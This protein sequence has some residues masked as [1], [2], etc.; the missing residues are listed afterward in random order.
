M[1][2]SCL[3]ESDGTWKLAWKLPWSFACVRHRCLLVDTCPSCKRRTG[4]GHLNARSAPPFT[5]HI[6]IPSTCRN[7]LLPLRGSPRRAPGICGHQLDAVP[8]PPL[9]DT[10]LSSILEAQRRIDEALEGKEQTIAGE[11]V[12]SLEYFRDLRSACAMILSFGTPEDIEGVTPQAREAFALYA[13]EREALREE[14]RALVAAGGHWR[15]GPYRQPYTA[16]QHSAALMAAIVPRA[17]TVL[18]APFS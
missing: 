17:V 14:R 13:E 18:D 2:P 16:T 1:C 3:Q 9:G 6:P 5:S 12:S 10:K 4:S 8:A 15:S 7:A 11:K